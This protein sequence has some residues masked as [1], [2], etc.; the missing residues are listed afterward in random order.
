MSQLTIGPRTREQMNRLGREWNQGQHI[1]ITGPTG[2]G[3]TVLARQVLNQRIKRGGMVIV[4]CMKPKDDPTILEEYKDF[5]RWT[6]WHRRPRS[7]EQKILLW[8]DVKK[9]KGNK[10][11]ILDI[12]KPVFQAAFDGVNDAG[13]WCVQVDEGLYTVAPD[14][15]RMGGDL[16]MSHSI[17]R[18]GRLSMLTLAQ[19]PAHIPLIV[20]GS[21]SHAFMG[22]TR[23][24]ADL[25]R[26][27]ELGTREGSKALGERISAQSLH[28]FTWLPVAPD[29]PAESVNL[30]Q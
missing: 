26:L 18:S 4:F 17:G 6:K 21:A 27:A 20:Y 8:P 25:K 3:K 15:L 22:R 9:A 16:A 5:E 23:E 19:R 1:F 13:H 10:D 2:S 7:Y 12:Q 28:D 24:Q 14:F 29:W 11:A 30:T